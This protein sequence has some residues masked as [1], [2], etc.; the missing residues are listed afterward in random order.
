[1]RF[2][3]E[4]QT[5]GSNIFLKELIHKVLPVQQE[6]LAYLLKQMTIVFF[7]CFFSFNCSSLHASVIKEE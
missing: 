3:S 1:M 7:T 5:L 2:T 4:I 6:V